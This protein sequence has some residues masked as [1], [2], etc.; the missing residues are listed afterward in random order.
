MKKRG[1]MSFTP[2]SN[3]AEDLRKSFKHISDMERNK[4]KKVGRPLT[5][6]VVT[7]FNGI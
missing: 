2:D 4:R 3:I 7:C 1:G 5:G 6:T